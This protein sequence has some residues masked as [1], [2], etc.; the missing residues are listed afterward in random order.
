MVAATMLP[1]LISSCSQDTATL[2]IF[3]ETD[4]ITSTPGI[5]D[6]YTRTV[7]MD[8]VISN[9]TT[10][11]LGSITDP[12]TNTKVNASFAAQFHTY[13]DTKFPAKELFTPANERSTQLRD[14]KCDSID[15]HLYYRSF[16]GEKNNPMKL[17]VYELSKDKILEE[18]T[19]YYTSDTLENYLP[20]DAKPIATKIFSPVDYSLTDMERNDKDYNPNIHITLPAEYGTKMLNTYY[21]HP[22]YFKDSY[23]FIRNVCPGFYFKVKSGDGTVVNVAVSTLNLFF[24]YY[25][26]TIA[27]SCYAALTR[28]SATP[29]VIQTTKFNN[30]DL[31]AYL[32]NDED[33]CTTT[34]LKTPAGFCTEVILPIDSIFKGH[35]N[36]SISKAQLTFTRYNNKSSE[37]KDYLDGKQ[38]TDFTFGIPKELLLVRK[39][40]WADFFKKRKVADSK[41]AYTTSFSSAFNTYTFDNIGRLLSLCNNLKKE[42]MMK[43][44]LTAEEWEAKY[45]DWN[46]VVLVP[47]KTS[48]SNDS[49]GNQYQV[50][51]S[52][53]L[54]MNSARLVRGYKSE[55]G[56]VDNPIKLQIIFSKFN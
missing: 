12:E 40:D 54:D 44:H 56:T 5:F 24:T 52:N 25:H 29:E 20:A 11:Y 43:E 19:E 27:D 50:S 48:T 32:N 3:P 23:N 34:Y 55:D 51:V 18:T 46:K 26:E 41:N 35:E 21:E 8:S 39:Q 2:G 15:I 13:E 45:P 14:V 22:E 37:N 49:S 7:L 16:F 10:S 9:S 6:V 31:Q 42:G 30:A 33:S 36:D 28:F 17:E 47:V 4:N 38:D 1:F 53:D